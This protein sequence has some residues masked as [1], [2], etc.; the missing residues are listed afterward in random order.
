MSQTATSSIRASCASTTSAASWA[1]TVHAA[2]ARAIGR[3]LRHARAAQRRQARGAGLRRPAELA[4]TRG[5]LHRGPDLG[6]HRRGATSASAATPMLYFAVYHLEADGGIQITGSHNPPDYNGFKMMMGKK[7]FFGADDPDA[8]RD[9][10]A[11]AMSGTGRARSRSGRSSPTTSTRLLRG[12]EARHEA[13]GRLGHRQR[14]RGRVDPRRCRR[15]ARRA[16]I[17]C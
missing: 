14:R 9:G 15:Q 13:Q 11:R 10:R 16:S 7:S 4:R 8:G 6:R 3:T 1:S 17:S 12:R 2:D 5:G